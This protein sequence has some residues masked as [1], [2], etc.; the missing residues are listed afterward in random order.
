MSC[1]RLTSAATL[2]VPE[3]FDVFRAAFAFSAFGEV[4]IDEALDEVVALCGN[5]GNGVFLGFDEND[6]PT[7]LGIVCLPT[8]RLVP[9]PQIITL[10]SAGPR[11][12][13][14]EVI[15]AGL[16]FIKENGH[17]KYWAINATGHSDEVWLRAFAADEGTPKVASLYEFEIG[18]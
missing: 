11:S 14:R 6:K 17:M 12:V 18:E 15:N 13:K 10:F 5:P 16:A 7:A 1:I 8:T 4:A 3:I 2:A 9:Y